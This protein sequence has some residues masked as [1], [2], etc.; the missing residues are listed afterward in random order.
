MRVW[1]A[2]GSLNGVR[3]TAK[4]VRSLLKE[5]RIAPT[6]EMFPRS[7]GPGSSQ[8]LPQ[9]LAMGFRMW[10][11]EPDLND[12]KWTWSRSALRT[13]GACVGVE[14][15]T[16]RAVAADDPSEVQYHAPDFHGTRVVRAKSI[17]PGM[18]DQFVNN[19]LAEFG[20]FGTRIEAGPMPAVYR[21]TGL[22]GSNLAHAASLTLASA[23]SGANLSLGQI[24]TWGTVLENNFGV[25]RRGDNLSY[26]VSLT[27]GQETLT[28]L[29]GGVFDNVHVPVAFGLHA[30]LSRRLVESAEYGRLEEHLA[31]VNLGRRR[32][33][34]MTSAIVNRDWMAAWATVQHAELH[35]R[36]AALAYEGAEALRSLD[37]VT[38]ADV[39]RQYRDIRVELCPQYTAGQSELQDLC[40][41]FGGQYF[42]VGAGGGTCLV[43]CPR[44]SALQDL[45]NRI[46]GT[47]S[48]AAGR[49]V[50]PFSVQDSGIHF[51]GF[52]E[53]G[54]EIP[55]GPPDITPSTF[56]PMKCDT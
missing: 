37:F 18:P 38:Y 46:R 47:E 19:I 56:L 50:I 53:N 28:A 13:P 10:R 54:L 23:L 3:R 36:K 24:Y 16:F 30:V 48:Q 32:R 27:G 39:I 2:D 15:I 45:L 25:V 20:L 34:G 55:E 22:G 26:G 49:V 11:D 51:V 4:E 8:D 6:V 21:G 9:F 17:V 29:Q 7:D 5:A 12:P 43:C 40:E 52:C 31:L 42:P 1:R 41:R 35:L 33:E 44:S 14:P